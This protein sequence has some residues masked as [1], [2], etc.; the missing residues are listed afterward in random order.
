[1]KTKLTL[2]VTVLAA[3]LF[4]GGCASLDDGLIA[5]YPFSGNAKDATGNGHD[6][7]VNGAELSAD[8][9]GAENNSY[10]FDGVDDYI[11][12]GQILFTNNSF[13]VS[14]WVNISTASGFRHIIENGTVEHGFEGAFRLETHSAGGI[15]LAIGDG[16]QYMHNSR[17]GE[18]TGWKSNTWT[19]FA[20]S[21]NG[22]VASLYQNGA[23]VVQITAGLDVTKGDG[24]LGVGRYMAGADRTITGSIDDVRIYN[25]ALSASEVKDLYDLEKPK[26]K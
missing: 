1:M 2:F 23:L 18:N 11:D 26:S 9:H 8:R 13:T 24:T 10:S 12:M 16:S 22:S 3:A 14:V 21:Y 15:Y 7:E 6:G 19:L 20:V 4:L 25:R 5:H 17:I